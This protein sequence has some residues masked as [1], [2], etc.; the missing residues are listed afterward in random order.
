MSNIESVLSSSIIVVGFTGVINAG[1]IWYGGV[2]SPIELFGPSRFHWDSS[3]F[4]QELTRRA[5]SVAPTTNDTSSG[6]SSSG[7]GALAQPL[8]STVSSPSTRSTYG[9]IGINDKLLLY[10]YIG[11]NPSKGGL[12]RSGACIKGDGIVVSWLGHPFFLLGALSV[13][14][15]RIPPFFET[16]PLL[17]IDQRGRLRGDI[18]FRRAQS[19]YSIDQLTNISVSFSGG[20]LD[21]KSYS[22]PSLVKAYS[23]KSQFGE[24]FTFDKNSP[25]ADGVF[26]TTVR[27]WYSFSHLALALIFLFGHL[28]HGGRA[29][30]QD[31]TAGITI[32]VIQEV[33]EYGSNEKM[34][35]NQ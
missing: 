7:G 5:G 10:D 18:P 23:L 25:S 9:W 29:L 28:W 19:I 14:V 20:I 33:V 1:L 12:F 17:L 15:R 21:G 32:E 2:V 27:G 6:S 13:S 11:S 26:R 8:S 3:Y 35:D 4:S 34:G 24:I 16:F 31:L 22:R 30:F